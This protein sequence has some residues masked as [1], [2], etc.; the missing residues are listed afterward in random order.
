MI[1][2]YKCVSGLGYRMYFKMDSRVAYQKTA[3][4]DSQ[5]NW[6]IGRI[7]MQLCLYSGV[8]VILCCPVR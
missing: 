5:R 8:C 6:F 2:I 3:V 1:R 7:F 4:G